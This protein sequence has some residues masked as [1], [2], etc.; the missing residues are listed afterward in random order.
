MKVHKTNG[1]VESF[2]LSQIDSITFTSSINDDGLIAYYPFNGNAND[3]SGNNHNGTEHETS[4]TL[5][6][7]GNSNASSLISGNEGTN[8]SCIYVEIPNMI[9]GLESF[10][11]SLWV[12]EESM[13]YWHG[14]Y[15]ISFGDN[16]GLGHIMNTQLMEDKL[17]F[18]VGTEAGSFDGNVPFLPSYLN[19][20]QNYVLTYNGVTGEYNCYHN[21]NPDYKWYCHSRSR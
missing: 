6:R 7:F 8:G 1:D 10:T 2:L 16:S 19:G 12:D 21:N 18:N 3:E 15:Y 14:N 17:T 5:D 9:D 20:F 13:S 11:I 4:Y